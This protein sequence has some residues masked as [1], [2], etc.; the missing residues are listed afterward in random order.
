MK[1]WNYKA[2]VPNSQQFQ[3]SCDCCINTLQF[4][5]SWWNWRDKCATDNCMSLHQ[6]IE[7]G[8]SEDMFQVCLN[9]KTTTHHHTIWIGPI[10]TFANDAC[11][12]LRQGRCCVWPVACFVKSKILSIPG[13]TAIYTKG[14]RQ[15]EQGRDCSQ[16]Y[17][18]ESM[19]LSEFWSCGS[20][21]KLLKVQ[22]HSNPIE[23]VYSSTS[24]GC[25][26]ERYPRKIEALASHS[27]LIKTCSRPAVSKPKSTRNS[28]Y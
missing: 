21:C 4:F 20:L 26:C 22:L 27:S 2:K 18:A 15:V 6:P 17:V 12:R 5:S 19:Q 1:N 9:T 13:N 3:N 10:D 24:A 7:L 14:L 23:S 11:L 25:C 8:W 16:V 28:W